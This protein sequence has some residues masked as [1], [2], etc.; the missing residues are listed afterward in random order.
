MRCCAFLPGQ[1]KLSFG[2]LLS[3]P[4]LLALLGCTES[5]H[6]LNYTSGETAS[7]QNL[8]PE[9]DIAPLLNKSPQELV[10][11]GFAFLSNKNLKIAELHFMTAINK[12]PKMV[13]A[14]IGLGRT[15][16]LK[17]NYSGALSAFSK[18]SEL[19]PDSLP[20][21][22]GE[23]Q[24]FRY[25]GKLDAAI[26]KINAAIVIAPEDINVLKELA[27]IYD[28][29]GKENLSAPL[30]LE[31]VNMAPD[32][33]TS[34]NN[35]GLNYMVRGEYEQAINS[36]MQALALDRN[37]SRIKNNLASAYLLSGDQENAISIFKGT[38]GEAEAYN[39][40]GYLYMTQGR[41]DEAEQALNKA[42]QINPRYYVRAQE[43]LDLL[44]EMRRK[45]QASSL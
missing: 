36:F 22:I 17:G 21:L 8:A 41:F 11:A 38:V 13:D 19:K 45:A 25:D 4:L 34:H 6:K 15:E 16:M 20:A 28:L 5:V 10:S 39:N 40:I 27:L 29:M 26:K 33:A 9:D 2:A 24:A 23:A 14:Y 32:E 3:I 1:P 37:N 42:L 43:N 12:D 30:Y 35:L 44:H 18:A 31:I 7:L